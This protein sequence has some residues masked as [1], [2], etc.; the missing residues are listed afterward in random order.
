MTQGILGQHRCT[1]MPVFRPDTPVI[2]ARRHSPAAPFLDAFAKSGTTDRVS[3]PALSEVE[4]T[5]L[6]DAFDLALGK[7]RSEGIASAMPGYHLS[8]EVRDQPC[9]RLRITNHIKVRA[10]GMLGNRFHQRWPASPPIRHQPPPEVCTLSPSP[11]CPPGTASE[12]KIQQD[13]RVCSPQSDFD[14]VIRPQIAIHDPALFLDQLLLR[15]DP[16][17]ARRG[18]EFL[19]PETFVQLDER[20]SGDSTQRRRERRLPRPSATEYDHA[21]H[22]PRLTERDLLTVWVGHP[23]PTPLIWIWE[24]HDF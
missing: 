23:C 7:S 19:L 10:G 24:G 2:R 18:R 13:N 20:Q 3:R 4:G 16:F 14:R 22:I 9:K 1:T 8:R 11:Q 12:R 5:L 6:S 21:L 15:L 17:V